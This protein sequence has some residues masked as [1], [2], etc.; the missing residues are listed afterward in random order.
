M[1]YQELRHRPLNPST[2]ANLNRISTCQANRNQISTN[3]HDSPLIP[4]DYENNHF[5]DEPERNS[6]T[7]ASLAFLNFNT[8]K[9]TQGNENSQNCN[10]NLENAPSY[11][12]NQ[13]ALT[14]GRYPKNRE[15]NMKGKS[16]HLD[17]E[18]SDMINVVNS[19]RDK[20]TSCC[21]SY[22]N[23]RITGERSVV[24]PAFP[25]TDQVISCEKIV[26]ISQATSSSVP[27]RMNHSHISSSESLTEMGE[28]KM[29]NSYPSD[30]SNILNGDNIV[31]H[32]E[33]QITP[34]NNVEF[35]PQLYSYPSSHPNMFSYIPTTYGS[36]SNP[37]D[38][39]IWRQTQQN[40]FSYPPDMYASYASSMDASTL[41][42]NQ[43]TL[44]SHS[45]IHNE[46]PSTYTTTTLP[47]VRSFTTNCNCGETCQCVG[48]ISHPYND[49]TKDYVRSA[50]QILSMEN[51]SSAS[52]KNAST[53]TENE[54]LPLQQNLENG[55]S[56]N[57]PT[58]SSLS[59]N[60]EEQS[61]S[62]NDFLFVNYS[63][64]LKCCPG[65]DANY[66]CGA[67]CQCLECGIHKRNPG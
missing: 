32:I 62:E 34:P 57:P 64:P 27:R 48:C 49:A 45:Q 4:S 35:R 14:R 52:L 22:K 53:T 59:A 37:L 26:D 17:I 31:P 43:G 36:F 42:Q 46:P 65:G 33:S 54:S 21:V 15:I 11:T 66:L 55:S 63:F 44:F 29:T 9:D 30:T 28:A 51:A 2:I 8:S 24:V 13:N 7:S 40:L 67:D 41:D 60:G 5:S 1:A 39:S 58:P 12:V 56:P 25:S 3:G 18:I 47:E 20:G 16:R 38:V 23:S 50:W 19:S 61:L 6:Q 10:G